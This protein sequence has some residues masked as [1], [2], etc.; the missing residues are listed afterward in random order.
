MKH[1]RLVITIIIVSC[2]ATI[3]AQTIDSENKQQ[4]GAF[5]APGRAP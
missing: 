1:L 5:D 2:M 3:H 4:G